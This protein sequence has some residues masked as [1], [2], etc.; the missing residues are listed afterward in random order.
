M[1]DAKYGEGYSAWNDLRGFAN[2]LLN[3]IEEKDEEMTA[4]AVYNA[5][6]VLVNEHEGKVLTC[7]GD[8]FVFKTEDGS[9]SFADLVDQMFG[10]RVARTGWYDP[11]EDAKDGVNDVFTGKYYVNMD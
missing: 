3:A 4:A 6:W 8:E 5:M 11:E 7:N 9:E 10:E 2:D 1:R